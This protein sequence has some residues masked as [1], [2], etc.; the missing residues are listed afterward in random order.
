MLGQRCSGTSLGG[1]GSARIVLEILE[2]VAEVE[3][4]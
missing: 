2:R 1:V 4:I 3:R